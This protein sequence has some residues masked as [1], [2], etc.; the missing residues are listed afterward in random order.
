MFSDCE[1]LK[2]HSWIHPVTKR[3]TISWAGRELMNIKVTSQAK[4]H[5]A[6]SLV[7]MSQ[8]SRYVACFCSC[9]CWC[10]NYQSK[11]WT[12]FKMRF[13]NLLRRDIMSEK[14][15]EGWVCPG[16]SQE[17]KLGSLA[18]YSS[19]YPRHSIHANQ[20]WAKGARGLAQGGDGCL[21]SR[22]KTENGS[23]MTLGV[24]PGLTFPPWLL[25]RLV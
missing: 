3:N 1:R 8:T 23:E 15:T 7:E 24:F 12:K 4:V 19:Q 21:A 17:T 22:G 13:R 2:Y 11:W 9:F 10:V 6:F 18:K 25:K 14:W 16:Q 5:I 20:T